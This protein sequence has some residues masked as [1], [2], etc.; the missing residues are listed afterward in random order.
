LLTYLGQDSD[1]DTNLKIFAIGGSCSEN[2]DPLQTIEAWDQRSNSWQILSPGLN[3]AREGPG[4]IQVGQEIFVIGGRGQD[5]HGTVEVWNPD[6]AQ[7]T[8]TLRPDLTVKNH[9][10]EYLV[11]ILE[12][13]A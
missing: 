9:D 10:Q 5:T 11:D 8:W 4:V 3:I 6:L 1:P 13:S 12:R 2:R 7:S